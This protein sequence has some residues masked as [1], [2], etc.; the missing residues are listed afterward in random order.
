V[1]DSI[2]TVRGPV[3]PDKFGFCLPHEHTILDLVRIFP[4][5]LLAYDFQLLDPVLVTEELR[6][7][8]TAVE[9]SPFAA[10]GRPGLIDLTSGPRMGRDPRAMLKLAEQLDLHLVM[11]CG[12][13]REPWFDADFERRPVGELT[14]TLLAE[15]KAGAEGTG[16]RPGIIGELGTDRDFVSP[17]EERVLRAAAR[18]HHQTDL[19]ISLHARASKVALAQLEILIEERVNPRRVIAGHTDSYHD[20]DYHEELARIG[21]WVEFDTIRGKFPYM[22]ERSLRYV[23]EARR[24]GYLDRLLL[25]G[26]VCALSHL[27]ANGG[28]G[29]DYLPALFSRRLGEAGFSEEELFMLFVENPRRAL[30]GKD[31]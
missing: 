3:A 9:N 30:T 24:R 18:A 26:D 4:T 12:W 5:Q 21:A 15:I 16:I 8:V 6:L 29:Y 23:M 25:S 14:A 10:A 7:F 22:V 17:A 19:S 28:S 27:H 2:M 1:P 13:Y 20:P 11:G 31:G